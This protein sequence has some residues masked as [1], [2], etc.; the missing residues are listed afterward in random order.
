MNILLVPVRISLRPY[1]QMEL[2]SGWGRRWARMRSGLAG[3]YLRY[4]WAAPAGGGQDEQLVHL[5]GRR[6]WMPRQP[7]RWS[8]RWPQRNRAGRGCRGWGRWIDWPHAPCK[9]V[10]QLLQHR[11]RCAGVARFPREP[12]YF[13]RIILPVQSLAF[14]KHWWKHNLR[15]SRINSRHW[16]N[17]HYA[18]NYSHSNL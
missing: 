18:I 2:A 9:C 4:D 17:F 1:S 14:F 11:R 5:R 3:G 10:Q 7:D 15:D 16:M 6:Q 8:E 12:R 13:F